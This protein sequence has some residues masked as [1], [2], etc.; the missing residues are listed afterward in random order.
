M[1]EIKSMLQAILEGQQKLSAELQGFQKEMRDFRKETNE[2]LEKMDQRMK[3]QDRILDALATRSLEQETE[4]KE[5][6]RAK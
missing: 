1:E 6:K 5:L 2:R 3:R 4:I